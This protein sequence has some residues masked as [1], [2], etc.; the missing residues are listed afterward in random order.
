IPKPKSLI[1]TL[2]RMKIAR[3]PQW[4]GRPGRYLVELRISTN[5]PRVACTIDVLT[6]SESRPASGGATT[7]ERHDLTAPRW[8]LHGLNNGLIFG[9]TCRIVGALPRRLTYAI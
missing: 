6:P 7:A 2:H 3:G 9:A 1:P 8:T 5:C 4:L